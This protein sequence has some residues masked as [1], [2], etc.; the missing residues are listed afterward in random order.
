MYGLN[1]G[2]EH[3]PWLWPVPEN[4]IIGNGNVRRK[5][6]LDKAS[7]QTKFVRDIYK[8]GMLY[9]K[10]LLSP[11]A[12]ARITSMDTSKAEALP[13][14]RCV[15]RYDD[16]EIQGIAPGGVLLFGAW[17]KYPLVNDTAYWYRQPGMGVYIAAETEQ[18]VDEALRLVEIEWEQLPFNTDWMA[19]LEEGATV[20]RP[21]L[22][23]DSNIDLSG[24]DHVVT[25][26]GD[27]EAGFADAD[28]IITF[29][30]TKQ[31][32]TWAGACGHC[33]LVEWQGDI[34]DIW[35]TGYAAFQAQLKLAKMGIA[36]EGKIALHEPACGAEYGGTNW[37]AYTH[38]MDI[39]G[40]ILSKRTGRPVKVFFDEST[41]Y[42]QSENGGTISYKVGFKNDGTITAVDVDSY[43]CNY[44]MH[45]QLNR[46]Y[47]GT[48]IPNLRCTDTTSAV[49]RGPATTAR[50]GGT[51]TSIINMVEDH[52][53][54]A[55]DMDPTE[56][57]LVNDGCEGEDM[58]WVDENVKKV[59]GFDHTRDSL[60][61]C[62]AKGKA[63]IDWDNKWHSAGTKKLANGKYH[64]LGFIQSKEYEDAPYTSGSSIAMRIRD[65]GTL[66]I[67]GRY[68]D[69]GVYGQTTYC[70][71]V[72]DVIG[73]KLEDVTHQAIENPGIDV[74]N[75]AGSQG[76][77]ASI[78][79]MI[80]AAKMM[81]DMILQYALQE[82]PAAFYPGEGLKPAVP[83]PF[84]DCT[85]D[86]ID[87][88]DSVIY[89]IA[90]PSNS[91]PVRTVIQARTGM[92]GFNQTPFF[93]YDKPPLPDYPQ[94]YFMGR[95][96]YFFEVEVDPETGKF[97]VTNIALVNDVGRAISPAGIEA[98][99]SGGI[100]MGMGYCTAEEVIYDPTTGVKLNDDNINYLVPAM[101]DLG[102]I[103]C[104]AVETGLGY[105]AF[106]TL[107]I[108]EV[109]TAASN[110]VLGSAIYNAIGVRIDEFPITP[111]KILK[112]LGK[113]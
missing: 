43:Y 83:S 90:N 20:V 71:V 113:I 13:G 54:A 59:Q 78:P 4:G 94:R 41:F 105:G 5:D 57:A 108:G 26:Y 76:M 65:D 80:R 74:C 38:T 68:G 111:D 60:K 23:P 62:L 88:K 100:Y 22:N 72:A 87:I 33:E 27:V 32:D 24:T 11:Y 81:K 79:S 98:Q 66:N 95:L 25:V 48:K 29:T 37:F 39:I 70:Q 75:G 107:G 82:T 49:N 52:V 106:A 51:S 36:P 93:T 30:T 45:E 10:T 47:T 14:V 96:T 110:Q 3:K 8:P 97:D 109:V 89:E 103:Q 55:L 9:A 69:P 85:V 61:E 56:I 50:S 73:M 1:E 44:A 92:S 2:E 35:Y 7:A 40:S 16:P 99:Q 28:Q 112:A 34:L 102:P 101:N 17:G 67:L 12:H 64:G 91:E 31:E 86:E 58:A 21:E 84:K 53:A 15:V 77:Q 42:G 6:G 18:A 19:V 63:A 46:L 104:F